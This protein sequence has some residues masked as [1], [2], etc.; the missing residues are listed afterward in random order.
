MKISSEGRNGKK[1]FDPTPEIVEA[2][3]ACFEERGRKKMGVE[4]K[5][6]E[7]AASV[8]VAHSCWDEWSKGRPRNL[9]S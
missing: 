5:G 4:D 6:I 2:G 1:C 3:K 7:K 8:D 9:A